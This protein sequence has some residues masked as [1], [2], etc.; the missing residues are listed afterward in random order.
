M[1]THTLATWLGRHLPA[2]FSR[3]LGTCLDVLE[4]IAVRLANLWRR[5]PR[6]YT[7]YPSYDL[8]KAQRIAAELRDGDA[9]LDIGC[10][11]AHVLDELRLFRSLSCH[12]IDL[13]PRAVRPGISVHAFDGV[14]IPCA[15]QSFDV[16]LCC[17]VLHHLTHDHAR[18]LLAEAVRVSRRKL[19][20]LEDSLPEFDWTYRMRNRLHR[21][22]T[23]LE[24][25]AASPNYQPAQGDS[26]FLT[27]AGWREFLT[28]CAGV[29]SVRVVS[30]ADLCKY[31]HHT[32]IVVDLNPQHRN[33]GPEPS[34]ALA[35]HSA[36][37]ASGSI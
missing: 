1:V 36:G 31:R 25:S 19:I 32:M 16:A 11:N 28:R 10:G 22:R 18:R 2:V 5:E 27:H 6:T 35:W 7:R 26:M 12:G 20:L 30:V 24:Y 8:L 23:E 9:V 3:I 14:H 29:D 4:S 21:V 33:S 17:Y 34:G 13:A 15:D 37:F